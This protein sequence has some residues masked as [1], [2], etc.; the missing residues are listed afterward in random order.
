M[1]WL[2]WV[3]NIG[4]AGTVAIALVWLLRHTLSQHRDQLA[5]VMDSHREERKEWREDAHKRHDELRE[6]AKL[7]T[8]RVERAFDRMEKAIRDQRQ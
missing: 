8:D 2:Q 5:G 7:H 6:Q 4:A 1:D 3:G